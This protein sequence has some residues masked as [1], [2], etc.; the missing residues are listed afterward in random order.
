MVPFTTV[1]EGVRVTVRPVWQQAQS[2]PFARRFVF[3]YHIRIDNLG[4][5]EV[6]LL[7][8]TWRIVHGDGHAETVEGEGVVGQQPVVA[9]GES[10]VYTSFVVLG[11]FTG[12]MEGSYTMQRE[13]GE[14]FRVDIPR[15]FLA[16]MAN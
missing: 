1:T 10:F 6:Q 15:F 11:A 12:T 13:S 14:R 5:T 3:S 9:A 8:R 7:R 2:D 16:A 4:E